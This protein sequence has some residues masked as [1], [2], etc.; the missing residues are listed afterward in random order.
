MACGFSIDDKAHL[1]APPLP[2][3]DAVRGDVA[4]GFARPQRLYRRRMYLSQDSQYSAASVQSSTIC[5][6][7]CSRWRMEFTATAPLDDT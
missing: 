2:E 4:R 7:A 6:A 3:G 1:L 5:S